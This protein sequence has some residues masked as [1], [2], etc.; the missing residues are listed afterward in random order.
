MAHDRTLET[1]TTDL[2]DVA[3]LVVDTF[4]ASPCAVVGAARKR[5]EVPGD[6]PRG[7]RFGWGASGVVW[8]TPP[9]GAP[10]RSVESRAPPAT[11]QAI[12][13]LASLT[14]PVVALTLARLQRAGTIDRH[15]PL[16]AFLPEVADT[17]TG[18][19]SLDLLSAHR[20]GLEAHVPFFVEDAAAEQLTKAEVLLRAAAARRGAC[21]GTSPEG[22][23]P[24][25]Y[26]DLGYILLGEALARRVGRPLDEVIASEVAEPLG[27]VLGSVRQLRRREPLAVQRIVPTEHVAWRGGVVCAR[28]HDEN[29]WILEGE[30]SAGHAGQ[31]GDAW[32]LVRLGT[33]ILDAWS[34]RKDGWLS[35]ADLAPLDA[36]RPGG[37]H[38]AGFDRRSGETPSAGA[39]FG[40]ET[41]G[42]LGFTGTS[43]WLDPEAEL[44]GVLLTNR[45]HPTRDHIAIRRARPAVYDALF[46]ALSGD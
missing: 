29:A 9:A 8:T 46:A 12:F 27:L 38:A 33:Q 6:P 2:S 20:A 37:S 22:G 14:K 44:V 34:R 16:G 30:G 39:R 41:F 15:E 24:P 40:P 10:A 36:P 43:I 7:W 5:A 23:F 18:S 26:S 35:R 31:F 11:T 32:S 21:R 3:R 28:V 4:G 13:D 45:V 42:H 19:V 1:E 25:V 17:P